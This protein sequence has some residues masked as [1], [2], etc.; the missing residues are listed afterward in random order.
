M[1]QLTCRSAGHTALA[2]SSPTPLN[3]LLSALFHTKGQLG[4]LTGLSL[5][6]GRV[7]SMDSQK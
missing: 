2:P 1:W 7:M 6:K 3:G 4:S 5:G